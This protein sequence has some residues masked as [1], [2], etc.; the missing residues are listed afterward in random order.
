MTQI[1]AS[2]DRQFAHDSE[3]WHS[4]K[5]AIAASSGFQRWQLERD[6]QSQ[7][8]RLEQQVQRYLRETLETLA[9]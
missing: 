5:Y 1:P 8:I 6:I 4:L 7:G 9:Y 2:S 3:I